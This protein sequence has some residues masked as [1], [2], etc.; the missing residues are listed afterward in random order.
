MQLLLEGLSLLFLSSFSSLSFLSFFSF[1]LFLPLSCLFLFFLF[2]SLFSDLNL[3][4]CYINRNAEV[5]RILLVAAEEDGFTSLPLHQTL[6]IESFSTF[7]QSL[8]HPIWLCDKRGRSPN[9]IASFLGA[10]EVFETFLLSLYSSIVMNS[11]GENDTN[12]KEKETLGL[13]LLL[14][15]LLLKD[16]YGMNSV[17]IACS[18][19]K[20]QIVKCAI[21]LLIKAEEGRLL[22]YALDKNPKGK[23][24]S[25]GKEETETKSQ[26]HENVLSS[27]PPLTIQ[28]LPLSFPSVRH[29]IESVDDW[30]WGLMHH[31]AARGHDE[32]CQYLYAIGVDLFSQSSSSG[33]T[34]LHLCCLNGHVTTTQWICNIAEE[35]GVTLSKLKDV[36]GRTPLHYATSAGLSQRSLECVNELFK[37]SHPLNGLIPFDF[38]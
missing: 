28:R 30:G 12:E 36:K 17:H 19:G 18:V 29:L 26:T 1:F 5:C 34:P 3:L 6:P 35:T 2:C 13:S 38:V 16:K 4:G 9:H 25:K 22:T 23:K 7:P 11:D 8:S 14:E 33:V 32:I 37:V 10:E 15:A 31:A 21:S 24:K 27:S 20:T